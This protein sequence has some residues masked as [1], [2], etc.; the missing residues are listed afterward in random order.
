MCRLL[1]RI[2]ISAIIIIFPSTT[3]TTTINTLFVDAMATTTNT[4]KVCLLTGGSGT[5]GYAIAKALKASSSSNDWHIILLGRRPPPSSITNV[6][7]DDDNG[8]LLAYDTFVK[9]M[10][11]TNESSVCSTLNEHF[12]SVKGTSLDRLDLLVNCAGCSLG[13]EPIT[14]VS[15]DSFRTVMEINLVVPF[16]LSKWAMGKMAMNSN[17]GRIINIGSI[18]GESPRLHSVPYTTSKFAMGGLTRAFSVEGRHLAQTTQTTTDGMV[19]VCQINP[20]NVR[21]SL[22]PPEEAARREKEEG[23]VEADDLGNYVAMVANL[24][25]EA[26]VLESTVMP[27]RQPMVGRG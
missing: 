24:P 4:K 7:D 19:A 8:A 25:N 2:V 20:G 23:F 21:S 11:M 16:I 14:N 1:I 6:E 13:N 9:E 18:A 27:T 12:E 3:I 15:A 26:N 22:I 17:G 5:I 10:E